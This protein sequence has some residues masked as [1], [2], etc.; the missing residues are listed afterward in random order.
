MEKAALK[1]SKTTISI[2]SSRFI[3]YIFLVLLFLFN[4]LW[5]YKL[6]FKTIMGDDLS[7]WSYFNNSSSIKSLI[8]NYSGGKYRPIFILFSFFLFKL[9]SYHYTLYF[10]FNILFNFL[11]IFAFFHII[12]KVSNNSFIAFLISILFITSRFSYYNILQTTGFLMSLSLFI[13]LLIIYFSIDYLKS[14]KTKNAIFILI[15]NFLI[16]FTYEIYIVLVPFLFFIFFNKNFYLKKIKQIIISSLVFLPFIINFSLK[17][18]AFHSNALI[19]TAGQAITFNIA[20]IIT[21]FF[22]GVLNLFWINAGPEYLNGIT[23]SSVTKNINLYIAIN[24]LILITI[25]IFYLKS[26]KT[27]KFSQAKLFLLFILLLFSLLLAASITIRQELRWLFA[28]FLIFLIYFSYI[29]SNIKTV[30]YRSTFIKY[31][32]LLCFCMLTIKVDVY[33]KSYLPNVYFVSAQKISDSLY[34]QTIQKYGENIANFNVIL[35]KNNNLNWPMLN[36][37]STFFL[38]YLQDKKFKVNLVDNTKNLVEVGSN[39]NEKIIA[40]ELNNS[41]NQVQDISGQIQYLKS[42]ARDEKSYKFNFISN[43][44]NGNIEPKNKIVDTP[45]GS[46][47]FLMDWNIGSIKKQSMT[48]LSGFETTYKDIQI[49]EDNKLKVSFGMPYTNGDGAKVIIYAVNNN[50][51]NKIF[52]SDIK[53]GSNEWENID[54]SLKDYVGQKIDI[55]FSTVSPSG[56]ETADWIALADVAIVK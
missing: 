43:F 19:G 18:F 22:D 32:L 1:I 41:T 42:K 34:E 4:F 56:D 13:F 21:F 7:M 8:F 33:Y 40:L 25:F 2:L 15:L 31:L 23:F 47:V 3:T 36:S 14:G 53:P 45:N 35:I 12:K 49:G 51:K 39:N 55:I 52:D 38:P 17:I 20:R 37:D 27:E 30:G 5:F 10:Y 54:I 16:V 9:F 46:G 28:P 48:I 50:E 24:I 6:G 44:S 26:L 29:F 11:I